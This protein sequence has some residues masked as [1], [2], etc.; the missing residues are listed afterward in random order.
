MTIVAE[1]A[2]S[3]GV[4]GFGCFAHDYRMLLKISACS[5]RYSTL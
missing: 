3:F 1:I 2:T 5:K 4:R